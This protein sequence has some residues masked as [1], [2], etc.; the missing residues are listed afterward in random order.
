[1]AGQQ[2]MTPAPV[3]IDGT[4]SYIPLLNFPE[5][6][7]TP[8]KEDD[9][10]DMVKLYNTPAIGK[11]A[12]RRPYPYKKEHTDFIIS[13]LP[14]LD[15]SIDIIKSSLPHPPSSPSQMQSIRCFPFSALRVISTGKVIGSVIVGP[16]EKEEGVWEIGYDLLPSY[17]GKGIGK[18]MILSTLEFLR[19]LG[20][21]RVVAFYQPENIASGAVLSR[22][23]FT[24]YVEKELEWP[25]E[26]GGDKRLVYGMTI[27]L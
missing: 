14:S 6:R 22:L 13:T 21:K 12:C 3:R 18:C 16:G 19:W 24:K 10:D 15:A 25:E 8:W 1:M 4:E 7:L 17:W 9:V 20:I 11:W 5:I 2:G 27:D 23:G 26:K